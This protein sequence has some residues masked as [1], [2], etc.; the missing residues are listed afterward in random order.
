MRDVP[1]SNV[2]RDFL[3]A[4]IE[5]GKR[6]DGRQT[7]DYRNIKI[8]FGAERGCCEVQLG[9]TRVLS[10][11]SC[12]VTQPRAARPNEGSLI[13]NLELSPMASPSFEAG[14]F[15]E[16]AVELN[17][18]L[19]RCIRETR[20]LDL[21][22]LCIVS[23]EKVWH[24]RIDT[25]V[26]NHDGSLIDAASIATIAAL[27]HFR[28][29]DVTVIGESVTIHPP[30]DRDPVPLS[31]HH[32]PVCI[33]FA[34][35]LEGKYLLVDPTE[36]EESVMDGNMVMAMNVHREV[37]TVQMSGGMLLLKDQILRCAQISTVKVAEITELIKKALE[38]DT[39]AR[40]EGKKFGFAESLPVNRITANK[41][42][43][44]EIDTS[45]AMETAQQIVEAAD[46]PAKVEVKVETLGSGVGV[47]GEG[48]QNSWAIPDEE[49]EMDRDAEDPREMDENGGEEKDES[50]PN[51][52]KRTMGHED[53]DDDDSEEEATVTIDQTEIGGFTKSKQTETSD[54][55]DL[56]LALKKS[57]TQPTAAS[58]AI[59]KKKTKRKGKKAK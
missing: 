35:Y 49:Q 9:Q 26:L 13:V 12:E 46:L 28:R 17:R 21:E 56:S 20:A 23:G 37:C 32:M 30:E 29:P 39:R 1:L 41:E 52:P 34:F 54:D 59:P 16:Y 25:H 15:S 19:E 38:N 18:L 5:K 44:Q 8:T 7:Y 47:I 48:G 58:G 11:V 33:T 4:A 55:L 6:L 36:K 27:S 50:K 3:L 10:Q 57:S 14:R 24:I 31:V 22:S 45:D 53:D 51:Q 43:S 40:S 42:E 2:E